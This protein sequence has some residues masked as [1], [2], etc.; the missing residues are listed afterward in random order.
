MYS[1]CLE[2]QRGQA[3]LKIKRRR[4]YRYIEKEEVFMRN[5]KINK[6]ERKVIIY[7]GRRCV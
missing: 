2:L 6:A 7:V 1:T 4:K 5:T 3:S